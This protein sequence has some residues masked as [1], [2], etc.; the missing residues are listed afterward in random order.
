M[1][2]P[3]AYH[4]SEQQRQTIRNRF[5]TIC[6]QVAPAASVLWT[7]NA[8]FTVLEGSV[9]RNSDDPFPGY[10]KSGWQLNGVAWPDP[11]DAN[12][13]T[14]PETRLHVHEP[15][16]VYR[17]NDIVLDYVSTMTGKVYEPAKVVPPSDGEQTGQALQLPFLQFFTGMNDE[18]SLSPEIQD[19]VKLFLNK[20][21]IRERIVLESGDVSEVRALIC[22]NEEQKVLS[23]IFLRALNEKDEIVE[24][25]QIPGHFVDTFAQLPASWQDASGPWFTDVKRVF[26]FFSENFLQPETKTHQLFVVD[27]KPIAFMARF[28][29][30]YKPSEQIEAEFRH[31]PPVMLGV[32]ET[33][34]RKEVDRV[35]SQKQYQDEMVEVVVKSLEEGDS[36]P[37]LAPDTLYTVTVNYEGAIRKG[38]D[39]SVSNTPSTFHQEFKF[40]TAANPPK[41]LN[42]WMLSTVP[43]NDADG[44]FSNDKVQFIFNDAS[45]I[46]LFQ[47]FGKELRAVLRR[48]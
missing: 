12:R 28:E 24:E 27:W 4:R 22:A 48:S 37:L 25:I 10:S 30:F 19:L 2:F 33:L 46:Q 45:A 21:G 31:P 32:V 9:V 18:D 26:D 8:H 38:N 47:A 16:Y 15:D 3:R 7:F 34:T 29:I 40:Q 20:A 17:T 11:P 14:N 23:H 41:R 36:R 35:A 43:E 6:L 1:P 39:H 13:S 44:H 5:E 42:P